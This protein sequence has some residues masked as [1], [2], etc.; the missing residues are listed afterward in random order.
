MITKFEPDVI[1]FSELKTFRLLYVKFNNEGGLFIWHG[2]ILKIKQ[3][4]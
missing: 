3:Q 4:T 1:K 2:T